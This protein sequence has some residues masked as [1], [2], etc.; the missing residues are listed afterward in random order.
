MVTHV[1][2]TE[3]DEIACGVEDEG[4]GNVACESIPSILWILVSRLVQTCGNKPI[5]TYPAHLWCPCETVVQR[6]DV[7]YIE[8][9]QRDQ[10]E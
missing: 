6:L 4:F 7:E 1:A 10:A 5:M 3:C 9:D 8:R 2:Q